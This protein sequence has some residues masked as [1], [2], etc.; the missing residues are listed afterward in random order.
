M[1]T[2]LDIE[3]RNDR[4]V[5]M[6]RQNGMIPGVVYGPKQ[7]NIEVVVQLLA[8]DK[9]FKQVGESTVVTLRGVGEDIDVL[10]HGVEV[11]PMQGGVA[12]VDFYALEKGKEVTTHVPLDFIGDAPAEKTGSIINKVLHELEITCKPNHL[13]AKISVDMSKLTDVGQ[14]IHVS[15]IP[16]PTGV[17]TSAAPEEVIVV[18]MAAAVDED[19]LD[20]G[21]VAVETVPGPSA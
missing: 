19:E 14:K 6:L 2:T 18:V 20:E 15:D 5:P 10:I 1:K 7:M 21:V 9:L 11:L 4:S 17:E 13:P 8:F 16:L 12:H 3:A